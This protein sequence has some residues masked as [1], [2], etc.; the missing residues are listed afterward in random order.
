MGILHLKLN[1]ST[2]SL[3][4]VKEQ[5]VCD[6]LQFLVTRVSTQ[7]Q[8]FGHRKGSKLIIKPA[9]FIA[10]F[11]LFHNA[12]KGGGALPLQRKIPLPIT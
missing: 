8:D 1:L 2:T 7:V 11:S 3:N 4:E 6:V 10:E 9:L 5:Q 12:P